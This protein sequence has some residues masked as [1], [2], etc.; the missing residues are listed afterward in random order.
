MDVLIRNLF[1][2]DSTEFRAHEISTRKGDWFALRIHQSA[3]RDQCNVS[4]LF[5]RNYFQKSS[6]LLILF[7]S[8]SINR[9]LTPKPRPHSTDEPEASEAKLTN[10]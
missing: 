7:E 2:H 4:Q 6:F 5:I 1:E 8:S 9:R 3:M 10:Q